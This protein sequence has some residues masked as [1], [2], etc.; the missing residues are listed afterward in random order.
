[1]LANSMKFVKLFSNFIN[2]VKCFPTSTNFSKLFA[3]STNLKVG[4]TQGNF[5]LWWPSVHNGHVLVVPEVVVICRFDCNSHPWVMFSFNCLV[6]IWS[7]GNCLKFDT[8][9]QGGGIILDIVGQGVAVYWKL[10][11][12]YGHH[13]C[14]IPYSDQNSHKDQIILIFL[15]LIMQMF[16]VFV[17]RKLVFHFINNFYKVPTTQVFL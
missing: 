16:S 9:D 5:N 14:I 2:F 4:F 8:Q 13:M 6:I 1:M 12:F 11:N 3:A 17:L 10:D 15:P 7:G